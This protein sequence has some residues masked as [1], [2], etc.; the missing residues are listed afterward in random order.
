[1]VAWVTI[2]V[3]TAVSTAPE[4]GNDALIVIA[5]ISTVG[6]VFGPVI[7]ALTQWVL[8]CRVTS[9]EH[10]TIAAKTTADIA[11]GQQQEAKALASEMLVKAQTQLENTRAILHA[12]QHELKACTEHR[13]HDEM[14]RAAMQAETAALKRESERMKQQLHAALLTL[15]EHLHIPLEAI[16]VED[17]VDPIEEET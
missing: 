15:Q 2:L 14:V 7:L 9:L 4:P 16:E 8:S 10:G 5:I 6:V 17:V 1:M 11:I 12:T 13:E 3:A